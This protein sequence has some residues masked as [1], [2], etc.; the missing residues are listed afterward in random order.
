[1]EKMETDLNKNDSEAFERVGASNLYE[2]MVISLL[3]KIEE[4]TRK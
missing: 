3:S 4:N 2:Y 1:M